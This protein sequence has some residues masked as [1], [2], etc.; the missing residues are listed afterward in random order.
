MVHLVVRHLPAQHG[1][2]HVRGAEVDP[3]PDPGADDLL[4]RIREGATLLVGHGAGKHLLLTAVNATL[5]VPKKL[6]KVR[7]IAPLTQPCPEG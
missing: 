5:L 1:S 3:A 4:D 2:L 6:L 7:A